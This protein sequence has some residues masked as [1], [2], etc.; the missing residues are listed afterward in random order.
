MEN[1]PWAQSASWRHVWLI[2]PSIAQQ[3]KLAGEHSL[4]SSGS[5]TTWKAAVVVDS[6]LGFAP[7]SVDAPV[8]QSSTTSTTGNV[9]V[10]IHV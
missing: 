9:L 1:I 5:A 6:T 7:D 10:S 4:I 3:P 8:T 2:H